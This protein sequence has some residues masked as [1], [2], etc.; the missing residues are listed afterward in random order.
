MDEFGCPRPASG[1]G[2]PKV[3]YATTMTL[4]ASGSF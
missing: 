3:D 4:I 1:D 2:Q